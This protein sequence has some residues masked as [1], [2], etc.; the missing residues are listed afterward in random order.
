MDN[1]S[2]NYT[3]AEQNSISLLSLR[4]RKQMLREIYYHVPLA[5]KTSEELNG[6]YC[7][8]L[9]PIAYQIIILRVIPKENRTLGPTAEQLARAEKKLREDLSPVF[10]ELET[11]VIADRI[12]CLFNITTHRDSPGTD[13]FK[14]AIARF[15]AELST[16]ETFSDCEF[17][18]AEGEAAESVDMLDHCFRTAL[19]AME[20]G[21][22]Y[23]LNKRY[24]SYEQ[25]RQLGNI[26][27]I[28]TAKRRNR[29]RRCV[30]TLD[31]VALDPLIEE[32]F[33]ASYDEV[34]KSPGLAY[35]LP[36]T[37]LELTASA[38]SDCI[39]TNAEFSELLS[40]LHQQIDSCLSLNN[41][42]TLTI[43]SVRGLCGYYRDNAPAGNS[44]VITSAKA[45]ILQHYAEKIYLSHIAE[46]VQ[47][48]PQYLSVLFKA[49]AGVSI[50]DYI[51]EVRIEQAKAALRGTTDSINQ[52]AE[53]VGYSDPHYF[54]RVFSNVVGMSP[55]NYRTE[56]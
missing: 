48:N 55:K 15:F 53:A 23:G 45:Y 40:R 1:L 41:L 6:Y 5:G 14:L 56:R 27:S 34:V 18:M 17:V 54:S 39:Q 4:L 8:H 22:I 37:I 19:Q 13:Q 28:M 42:L 12:L 35:R 32:L 24:D 29:L 50:T 52:I 47:L 36:H 51:T 9:L 49:E 11:A 21:V 2:H 44:P 20:Y 38:I 46:Y 26:M 31:T 10:H 25:V 33:A 16:S 3:D 30:E 7:Y 43:E